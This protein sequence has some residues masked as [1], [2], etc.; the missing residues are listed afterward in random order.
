M[1]VC[2]DLGT[3]EIGEVPSTWRKSEAL[4]APL[5]SSIDFRKASICSFKTSSNSTSSSSVPARIT[6][7]ETLM[8]VSSTY[9]YVYAMNHRGSHGFLHEREGELVGQVRYGLDQAVRE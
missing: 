7:E 4:Y 9:V 8:R 2:V 1:S 6:K 3:L 5:P